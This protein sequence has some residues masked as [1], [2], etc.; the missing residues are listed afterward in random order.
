MKKKEKKKYLIDEQLL[1]RLKDVQMLLI[2][3][4]EDYSSQNMAFFELGAIIDEIEN[5]LE[6]E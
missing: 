3:P 2:G 1:N 6:A 5:S 4:V